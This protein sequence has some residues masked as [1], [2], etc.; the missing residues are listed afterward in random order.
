MS[1]DLA[2]NR[3]GITKVFGAENPQVEWVAPNNGQ[4]DSGRANGH[5]SIVLVHGLNGH[6]RETWTAKNGDFWPAKLL[7]AS[8]G[9]VP[10][11]ILV[12]GYDADVNVSGGKSS[13]SDYIH[14]HAQTLI[15]YLEA[16]RMVSSA[17]PGDSSLRAS[18]QVV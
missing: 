11:R 9:D 12:Y 7:P 4:R 5:H 15:T 17:C 8:L 3:H 16:D 10:S 2:V 6:P 18:G 14:D 1:E 13:T